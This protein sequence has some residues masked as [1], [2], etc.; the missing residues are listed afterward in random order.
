MA[1]VPD[2][3]APTIRIVRKKSGGGGHH[4]GAWK[5]AYA[6]FVTAMFAFFMVMWIMGL[7]KPIKEA[8][9][10]FFRDPSGYSKTSHGGK[11]PL[12]GGD[13][14]EIKKG[15]P[16]PIIPM[17]GGKGVP[18]IMAS[19]FKQ[20]AEAIQKKMEQ[21]PEFKNLKDSVQVKLTNEGLR[22]E[23]I[24]KTSSLF[25][26]T[27]SAALKSRT[28]RL[29]HL[30][31]KELGN[32]KNPIVIEGHTDSQPL[33]RSD[34]YSNWELSTDRANSARRAMEDKGLQPKQII[35]V[36][37]F[38]D[39]KLLKP[40]EPTHFSNRRVSILVAY[41]SKEGDKVE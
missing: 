14:T 31:A 6:D 22:I 35:A 28:V 23:L 33:R 38:A 21:D 24:E 9:A 5:V 40:E 4:G 1:D 7:S 16:A 19:Q 3:E 32:L 12:S 36:R 10:A 25:F 41:T 15:P 37:G 27:G 18:T 20:A 13:G 29:L 8:I 34:G 30:I 39:R 11:N 26:D 2:Q 17:D